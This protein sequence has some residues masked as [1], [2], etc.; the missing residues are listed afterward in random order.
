MDNTDGLQICFVTTSQY[1]FMISDIYARYIFD[2]Y[3]IK[4]IVF[5]RVFDNFDI[6]RFDT[7]GKYSM[8]PYRIRNKS[9][10]GKCLFALRCG[11]LFRFSRWSRILEPTQ[12]TTLFVFNDLSK[13]ANRLMK[14][15]K[16]Y[17]LEN[18]VFLVEEGNS[19]Y[20]DSI[21]LKNEKLWR[22]KHLLSRLMFGYGRT[23][24]IIGENVLIDGAIVKNVDRYK[25]LKK[26]QDQDVRQQ[27]ILILQCAKDFAS[28]YVSANEADLE[29]DVV[30]LGQAFYRTG[31]YFKYEDDCIE[32]II[33]AIP[34]ETRVLLK[35]H[36]RDTVSKY[37][38]LLKTH[39]NLSLISEKLTAIPI[40]ALL[41]MIKVKVVITIQSSAALTIADMYP[42]ISVVVV[43]E[44]PKA[45]LML[46]KLKESGDEEPLYSNDFF[47]GRN[48]NIFLPRT[49]EE[50]SDLLFTNIRDDHKRESVSVSST[51]CFPEIDSIV[52]EMK[53]KKSY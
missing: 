22:F 23:S 36:P 18:K 4:S 50:F 27:S 33:N 38:R 5:N 28:R 20:S 42:D 44:L 48:K 39:K 53:G 10:A 9:I 46:R 14:Q 12:I 25:G 35:P 13:L 19:T 41:G 2:Q 32:D 31:K 7:E 16:G 45:I 29:T 43:K 52:F 3:G 24:K 21:E 6:T 26:A 1:Q 49:I 11:Y 30:Y 40:E 15:V 17:S 34:D 8:F 47:V 37:N 51:E